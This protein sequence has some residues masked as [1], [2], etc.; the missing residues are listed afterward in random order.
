MRIAIAALLA[1]AF[2]PPAAGRIAARVDQQPPA[3]QQQPT[4]QASTNVVVVDV[5]VFDNNG[6]PVRDLGTEDFVVRVDGVPRRI[7]SAQFI[8]QAPKPLETTATS[9]G[10]LFTT[11]QSDDP[12]RLILL[13]VDQ[14]SI[15]VGGL[16]ATAEVLDHLF[17]GFGPSD[18]VGLVLLPGPRRLVNFGGSKQQIVDAVRRTAVSTVP[19]RTS[20]QYDVSVTEAFKIERGSEEALNQAVNRSLE[21]VGD[22]SL[23]TGKTGQEGLEEFKE[24]TKDLR[25]LLQTEAGRI[26]AESRRQSAQFA[27]ALRAILGALAPI[28]AP[29]ILIVFS[30]GLASPEAASDMAGLA[31]DSAAA[32]ARIHAVRFDRAMFDVENNREDAYRFQDRDLLRTGLEAMAGRSGGT[33][34]E[35]TGSAAIPFDRLAAEMSGYYLLGLEATA[36]DRD[37][38]SHKI[39]VAVQGRGVTVRNRPEFVFERPAPARVASR[40][41]SAL[42]MDALQS[43][44]IDKHLPV[45]V[46]TYNMA[47]DDP[48]LVRLLVSVEIDQHQERAGAASIGYLIYDGGGKVHVNYWKRTELERLPSGALRLVTVPSVPAGSYTLRLAAA[49]NG[50]VGSV[51]HRFTASLE[52]AGTLK[53]GDLVLTD[54]REAGT[55]MA[56]PVDGH[57]S[58]DRVFGFVQ[59]GAA[60]GAPQDASFVL[61]FARNDTAP[62]LITTSLVPGTARNGIQAVTG[63]VDV[64]LLPPGEYR[65]R[66]VVSLAG[67]SVRTL[68]APCSLDAVPRRARSPAPVPTSRGRAEAARGAPDAVP[69]EVADV[70]APGV[71]G[72]FLDEIAR[73]SQGISQVALESAKAGRFDEALALMKAPASDPTASFVRGAALLSKKNQEAAAVAFRQ[74]ADHAP[75]S[76]VAPFYI[77][78]CYALGGKDQQA[79]NAWQTSLIGLDGFPVVYRVLADALGR[80]GQGQEAVAVLD[81]AS[82]RWPDD[83]T[84]S[85]RL[86]KA[87]I[88]AGLHEQAL[89]RIEAMITKRPGDDALVFLGLQT[90]YEMGMDAPVSRLPT[91]VTRLEHYRDLYAAV[92]GPR[93]ALV[94][95]WIAYFKRRAS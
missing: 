5:S 82:R 70:L 57:M 2:L 47:D 94:A 39:D 15:S 51:E 17:A 37:G 61:E 33:V 21:G 80:L 79:A 9:R 30:Q 43:P 29:K 85:R 68:F 66:L 25:A 89:T 55:Q 45:R 54:S 46:V 74:V 28:D 50:R 19:R 91:L 48:L 7:S 32:R 53:L 8:D 23:A 26:V 36:T 88:A 40:D 60:K 69:F 86:A 76:M 13:V 92:N 84:L 62:A 58:T 4:F 35:V 95:E 16:R 93:Q 20:T 52:R 75:D 56:P 3:K 77:A 71:V 14:E 90:L 72:P 34:V 12:G 73:H 24:K 31:R 63:P 64:S 44:V 38:K 11:N 65:A 42:V 59:V 27:A 41:D 22:R 10:A 81:D 87:E 67:K 49:R 83:E 1:L 18:K 6:R 78:A